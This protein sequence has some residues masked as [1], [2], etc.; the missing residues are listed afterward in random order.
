MSDRLPALWVVMPVY[1]GVHEATMG[2]LVHLS[3]IWAAHGGAVKMQCVGDT[4][5]SIARDR[6]TQ[7]VVEAGAADED[8]VL[9]LDADMSFEPGE[10]AQWL[11][12]T[13]GNAIVAVPGRRKCLEVVW[14][15]EPSAD[16]S[17][18]A[19][20]PE[21]YRHL[22]VGVCGG[23]CVAM[24]G[25]T[26]RRLYEAGEPYVY[27]EQW[28]REVWCAGIVAMPTVED[29]TVTRRQYVGEDIGMCIQAAGLGVACLIDP[30][31]WLGHHDGRTCYGGRMG[32]GQ[33]VTLRGP[34]P[35]QG[36]ES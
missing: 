32:D 18:I 2:S 7:A 36:G 19:R 23:A 20:L 9:W 14:C 5:I 25:S 1:G 31:I 8:V 24:R 29:R 4:I 21:G 15:C 27:G 30:S 3:A 6:L 16:Q 13:P 28:R 11:A 12:D 35:C 22:L 26:L 17:A 10:V 34:N 33:G